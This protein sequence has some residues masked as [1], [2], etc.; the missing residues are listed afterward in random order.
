MLCGPDRHVRSGSHTW[1]CSSAGRA[2]RSQRGGRR[3]EPAHLHHRYT[4]SGA[5]EQTG[6]LWLSYNGR[7]WN[8]GRKDHLWAQRPRTNAFLTWFAEWGQV[9]Y[10]GV[11]VALLDRHRRSRADHRAAV[12]EVR[13]LQSGRRE[14]SPAE[15]AARCRRQARGRCVRRVASAGTPFADARGAACS[16]ADTDH[17]LPRRSLHGVSRV[18][19]APASP[20]PCDARAHPRDHA[21]GIA[22]HLPAVREVR[23]GQAR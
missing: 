21:V 15:A 11:Q 10:V 12:Q 3:F 8:H 23:E 6:R 16:G 18:P 7:G 17:R 13:D 1:G 4:T 22:A 5:A 14:R 9:A 20:Y 2:P 19:S